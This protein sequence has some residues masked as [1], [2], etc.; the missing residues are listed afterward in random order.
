MCLMMR[1]RPSPKNPRIEPEAVVRAGLEILDEEG[2][3]NITLRKIASRLGVQAPALYWH[4]KDKSD[5]IDDM[6]QAILKEGGIEDLVTPSDKS[7]WADWLT[8]TTHALH[9]AMLSYREGGRVVAGATFRSKAM[10]NLK[11]TS[12]RVLHD[13]GFDLLRASLASETLIDYVWGYVIEEQAAP[14]PAELGPVFSTEGRMVPQSKEF[15][16][17]KMLEEV[18]DERKELTRDELFDWGLQ[19]IINGLKLSLDESKC[20]PAK[21]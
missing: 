18:M 9:R 21:P 8:S 5:I 1:E 11:V 6:A 4:F 14:A 20:C 13:A 12:T 3:D 2:L 17:W 16:E 15:P 7:A 19:V 10:L